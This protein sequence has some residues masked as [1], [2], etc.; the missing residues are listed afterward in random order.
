MLKI[1]ICI[2][3]AKQTIRRLR[4]RIRPL[5]RLPQTWRPQR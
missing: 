1:W 4:R 5:G 2:N 3:K